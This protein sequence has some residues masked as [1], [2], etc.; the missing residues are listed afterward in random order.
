MY[1]GANPSFDIQPLDKLHLWGCAQHA[2]FVAA[3]GGP[4]TRVGAFSQAL[5][6]AAALISMTTKERMEWASKKLGVAMTEDMKVE[7]VPE[8]VILQPVPMPVVHDIPMP[9]VHEDISDEQM[10]SPPTNCIELRGQKP[11]LVHITES[12]HDI[13]PKIASK[14]GDKRRA[15]APSASELP[16]VAK[17]AAVA[18]AALPPKVPAAAARVTKAAAVKPA[19]KPR[20]APALRAAPAS[21]GA[22]V[23]LVDSSEDSAAASVGSTSKRMRI[24][25]PALA[26]AAAAAPPVSVASAA[27]KRRRGK[28]PEVIVISSDTDEELN[29]RPVRALATGAAKG[30]AK[31]R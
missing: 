6:N 14:A 13:A 29:K 26:P 15:A 3:S 24:T 23:V 17:L 18:P 4:K 25:G 11:A 10:V 7:F 21:K 2:S 22:P 20:A 8:T 5:S 30:A 19:P 16:V 1:L 12:N 31:R 9:A 28:E 27:G